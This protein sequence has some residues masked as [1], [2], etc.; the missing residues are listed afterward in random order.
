MGY[1]I[2]GFLGFIVVFTLMIYWANTFTSKYVMR[3]LDARLT[4]ME[5]IVNDNQVPDAW[6]RPFRRKLAAMRRTGTDDAKLTR[7]SQ[8]TQK[9]CLRKLEEMIRYATEAN[10]ADS[11]ETKNV[12]VVALKAQ[13]EVWEAMDW[14]AWIDLL[15]AP[16][17]P[18]ATEDENLSTD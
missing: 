4:D 12:V 1:A 3:V 2:L 14:P 18:P 17:A 5:Q 15:D 7:L 16:E 10:F 6:L 9:R 13:R 11:R 8:Q